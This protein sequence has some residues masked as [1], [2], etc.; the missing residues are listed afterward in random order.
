MWPRS[1]LFLFSESLLST[2]EWRGQLSLQLFAASTG[3]SPIRKYIKTVAPKYSL[4]MHLQ[5]VV[6]FFVFFTL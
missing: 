5:M 2:G 1:I 6:T 4:K 3:K